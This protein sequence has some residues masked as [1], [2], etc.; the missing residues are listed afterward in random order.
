MNEEDLPGE[1]KKFTRPADYG[2]KSTKLMFKTGMYNISIS[3][4]VNILDVKILFHYITH[5]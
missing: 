3:K 2:I 1:S 4:S 5:L